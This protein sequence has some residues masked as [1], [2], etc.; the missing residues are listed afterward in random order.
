MKLIRNMF[1]ILKMK[2][3][4]IEFIGLIIFTLWIFIL[5]WLNRNSEV[6][7]FVNISSKDNVSTSCHQQINPLG[8]EDEDAFVFVH[9]GKYHLI[10]LLC[11]N[12]DFK[13]LNSCAWND[14][15][16]SF[17]FLICTSV[18]IRLKIDMNNWMSFAASI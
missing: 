8:Q 18:T 14:E 5:G 9:V 16:L 12:I 11:S 2:R 4:H 6:D 3:K 17:R 10:H 1:T 13:L 7:Q 15:Q